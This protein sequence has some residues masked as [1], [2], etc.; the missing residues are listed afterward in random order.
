[1]SILVRKE[2]SIPKDCSLVSELNAQEEEESEKEE[3]PVVQNVEEEHHVVVQTNSSS[4]DIIAVICM[5]IITFIFAFFLLIVKPDGTSV[6]SHAAIGSLSI[7]FL[8]AF[9]YKLLTYS[10]NKKC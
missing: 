8:T 4:S 5:F 7:G 2:M 3:E 10:F 1:M 9:C 6:L